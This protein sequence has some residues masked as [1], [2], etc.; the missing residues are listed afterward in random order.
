MDIEQIL[1]NIKSHINYKQE[2]EAYQ[3]YFDMLRELGKTNKPLSY[4]HNLWLRKEATKQV[5]R[6]TD[7][8]KIAAFFELCKKTYLYM[9]K[10]DFDSY[11]LYLE[12][13]REVEKKFYHNRRSVLYPIVKDMQCLV[14]G[15]LDLLCIS[16]P[17][18]TGKAL[19]F[20]TPV[21][22]KNGWKQ[23]GDLTIRDEVIAPNGRFVKVLAIHPVC[24]MEYEVSFSNGEKIICHGNHEWTVYNRHRQKLEVLATKDMIDG[25]ENDIKGRGHRYHYMLTHR[26]PVQGL[27]KKLPV[28]PYVLGV[29]L[30]DGTNR[31]P[32]VCNAKTDKVIIDTV[33]SNG[34]TMAWDTVQKNT[35]VHYYGFKE[36]R[37]QLQTV[38]M[39]H[40]RTKTT[41]HIPDEYFTAN[42]GQRLELLAGLIDTDGCLI[43]V[44]RKYSFT[45]AEEA[46]RDDF[47]SLLSTFGWRCTVTECLPKISSSGIVGKR[48]YW[49]IKFNPTMEIPCKVPRKQL[50]MFSEQRR[51]SIVNIKPCK[52]HL[53]NCITV[54]GGE[55]L[56]GRRMVPT[57][58]S[59]LK[60]MLYSWLM[61]KF[62]DKPNLDSGHSG[63]MTSSTYEG[64][65]SVLSDPIEY[66]WRDVF[67]EAGSVIT[68]AKELTIDIGKKHRFSTLTCRA[69]GASL[70]G[71]T[72]CEGILG[73]DDL[74]SGI[75]ESMSK[76]R[77]DKKWD[78]YVNDLKSR[79]KEG[80]RELHIST[81]WSVHDVIGRLE[82]QYEGDPRAKFIVIPALD[83]KGE[84]NFEYTSGVGF[85]KKYFLDMKNNL[86]D[87]SF[88]CL[89][90][91]QPIER[92][93]QLYHP[94]ELRRFFE[95]PNEEPDAVL[96][97]C[98][99]KDKGT[100]Y[101]FLPV[102]YVYGQDHYI[103]DCV[104]DNGLPDVVDNR[105]V[106]ILYSNKVKMCRFESNSA[107]GRIA[108]KI[109][110]SV[111]QK[112]GIT[113]I[114]TKYTTANKETKIIVNSAWIKEHCLF[115]DD[116]KIKRDSD[117]GRMMRFLCSYSVAGKNKWDDVPDGMGMYADFVQSLVGTKVE[118]C[119]RPW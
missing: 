15:R 107:G 117:Y 58:N 32:T 38:G 47:V 26:D 29:W 105:L 33:L 93:G 66:L 45:T 67:P 68:N 82:R 53:G 56:V 73:A 40:S 94:D 51:V 100:D 87:V 57:H 79:K 3:D 104:C 74:V 18:G 59:T 1:S 25:I 42:I 7:V 48:T 28:D 65:L 106:N 39:C 116:T 22:T 111:K 70:T 71:A 85:S 13:N 10:D 76:E 21:L 92:E 16:L 36:L 19:A 80:A 4:E 95:L 64:V 62:P 52:G 115:L 27:E 9:A 96:A 14:D 109:Q 103:Y 83:E 86:D 112:G 20:E 118:V 119:K 17:P 55:Y 108:Q 77:L 61:G 41:K 99:T 98:D 114:T 110:E 12:W 44:E 81:R 43:S 24:D 63:M 11:M 37:Q 97:I 2:F 88:R 49:C 30:G 84:S 91:N 23:H 69:I 31:N 5:M 35:G 72:R 46:L 101:A 8:K 6:G 89:Y 34:Y 50:F 60:I 54:E 113:K 78:A 90:M 75:E 102:G